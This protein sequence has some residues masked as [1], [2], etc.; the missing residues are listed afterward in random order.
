[1]KKPTKRWTRDQK[2][3][4]TEERVSC[5]EERREKAVMRRRN[6]GEEDHECEA[7]IMGRGG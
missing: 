4:G 7:S 6:D 2:T 1:M 3:D 5:G